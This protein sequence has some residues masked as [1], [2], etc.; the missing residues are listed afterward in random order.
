MALLSVRV[1]VS[2]EYW[3]L[4]VV[5]EGL[6]V[7]G[8]GVVWMWCYHPSMLHGPRG[9]DTQRLF[10]FAFQFCANAETAN[11]VRTLNSRYLVPLSVEFT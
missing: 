6:G 7:L 8:F 1:Q 5:L 3:Q 2:A 9:V 4:A 11:F 10:R